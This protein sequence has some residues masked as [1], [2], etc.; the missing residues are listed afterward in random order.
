MRIFFLIFLYV[1][2]VLSAPKDINSFHSNFTQTITDEQK[3]KL[4]YNG[5]LWATKPQNALWKYTKPIQ[6]S[7]YIVGSKLTLIEPLIEQVTIRT[8]NDEIDF[9]EIIKKSKALSPTRYSA[10]VNGQTY[11]IEFSDDT[12]SSINYTDG[13]DNKI[14]IKFTN[15][16]T[17]Q[18]IPSSRFKPTFPSSFDVIKE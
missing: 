15:G 9:L 3:K 13:Y 7:V 10:T 16:I 17:N 2:T 4:T 6:K 14:M 5:E 12:L 1:S 18:P 11:F 8:L